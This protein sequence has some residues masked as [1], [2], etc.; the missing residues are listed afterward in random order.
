V[1][2]GDAVV[3]QSD[4]QVMVSGKTLLAKAFDN[5]VG[6]GLVVQALQ[7]FK[8]AGHPN[9]LYGVATVME[10]VGLRGATTSAQA[11][12]PDVALILEVDIAGDVPGIKPEQ[13]RA[14]LGAG[15]SILMYD[16]GLIPNL[17]LRDLVIDTAAEKDIPLQISAYAA[18]GSTDG[19]KIHLQ[20]TGVP[21][22][23]LGIPTRHLHSHGSIIHRDDYENGLKLINE[24]VA[25][26]DAATVDDF[27]R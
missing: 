22:V 13:S 27:T 1:R 26:L 18:G 8:E 9:D 7:H 19:A 10:E 25:R 20:G 24:V 23:V 6:C 12:A 15:P 21:T 14:K 17:K 3:P 16:R 5:R 2:I 11:I 4:F